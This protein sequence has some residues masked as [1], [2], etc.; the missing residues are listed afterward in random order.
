MTSHFPRFRKSVA[1]IALAPLLAAPDGCHFGSDDVSLGTNPVAGA[2]GGAGAGGSDPATGGSVGTTGGSGGSDPGAGGSGAV[3]GGSGGGD[4]GGTGGGGGDPPVGPCIEELTEIHGSE[5]T[6]FGFSA[7]DVNRLLAGTRRSTIAT[8]NTDATH[9]SFDFVGPLRVY[10]VDSRANPNFNL[11]IVV[12]CEDHVRARGYARFVTDDGVFDETFPDFEVNLGLSSGASDPSSAPIALVEGG[13]VISLELSELRGSY[14]PPIP[15]SQ[16]LL[17]LQ[18]NLGFGPEE[19]NGSLI[20]SI[21]S[22]PCGSTDPDAL[23]LGSDLGSFRCIGESCRLPAPDTIVVEADSC[24]RFGEQVTVAGDETSFS[25]SGD[26]LTR[27]EFWG[28]GCATRPEHVM[29]Y[30][31]A[32]PLELRLCHDDGADGCEAGC[33]GPLSYDLSRPLARAGATEFVFVD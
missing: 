11:D 21:L 8:R 19:F 27:E 30:V 2:G 26:V 20:E 6:R 4:S 32:S 12:S 15:A 18:F 16:C 1:V 29:A 9:V 24:D 25:R 23:V 31:P 10:E 28:C 13:G 7:E 14:Y 3:S 33:S 5:P 17:S 22:M